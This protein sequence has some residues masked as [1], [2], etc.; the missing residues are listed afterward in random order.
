MSK[1]FESPD[2]GQTIYER[3]AGEVERT[4]IRENSSKWD[5]IQEDKLWGNIRRMGKD[6]PIMRDE[7]ERVI[8]L[9]QL[10]KQENG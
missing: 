8:I 5:Q 7:L 3:I 6:N 2:G 4:M 9:Y 10:L 1:I